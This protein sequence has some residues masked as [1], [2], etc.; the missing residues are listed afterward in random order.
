MNILEQWQER[1]YET[2]RSRYFGKL[3]QEAVYSPVEGVANAAAA[4]A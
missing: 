3:G 1:I 2:H 4:K